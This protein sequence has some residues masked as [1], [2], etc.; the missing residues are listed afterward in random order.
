MSSEYPWHGGYRP[1]YQNTPKETN[2]T[3]ATRYE[4]EQLK[5]KVFYLVQDLYDLQVE[6]AEFK[7][8]T[9]RYIPKS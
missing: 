4:F 6:L 9:H 1:S 7:K 8:E 5:T 2:L 3:P